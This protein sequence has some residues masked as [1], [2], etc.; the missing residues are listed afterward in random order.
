M[1]EAN[2]S[3]WQIVVFALYLEGGATKRVHTE[4]V[5]LRAFR[6][7]PDAFSWVKYPQY[8]DKDIVRVALTDARKDR[9]GALVVGRAGKTQSS[10]ETTSTDGWQLTEEGVKWVRENETRLNATLGTRNQRAD[11][12][13]VLKALR[14]LRDSSLF[15]A[16]Q[17]NPESFVPTLGDLAELL[18]CRVDAEDHVWSKRFATLRNHAQLGK[19]SEILS[20]LDKCE[21]L[22]PVLPR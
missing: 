9:K 12:Q 17:A 7:A 6:L 19:E 18:R 16:F 20:F 2:L 22:R 11:R 21:T 14:H 5:A 1:T 4:D 8:P 3:G 15:H 10:G 13:H